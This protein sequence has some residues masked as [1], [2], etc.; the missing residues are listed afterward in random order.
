VQPAKEDSS[1]GAGGE[2]LGLSGHF[3]NLKGW[4]SGAYY[5]SEMGMRELGWTPDGCLQVF[6]AASILRGILEGGFHERVFKPER[7]PSHGN[8]DGC[9]TGAFEPLLG[10]SNKSVLVF[11][12]SSDSNMRW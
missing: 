1:G 9:G 3:E 5:S 4:I 2:N 8:L 12:K 6:P 11:T 10:A 7:V